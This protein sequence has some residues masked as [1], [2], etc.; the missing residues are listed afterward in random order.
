MPTFHGCKDVFVVINKLCLFLG[1]TILLSSLFSLSYA[2]S[3]AQLAQAETSATATAAATAGATAAAAGAAAMG[4]SEQTQA[5][6]APAPEPIKQQ[7]NAM[8]NSKVCLP[9]M[10]H[11][12]VPL[13]IRPQQCYEPR[14]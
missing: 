7:E 8:A 4:Q 14:R 9:I 11:E 13:Y 3:F 5:I 2:S 10:P 6:A 1:T 12:Q